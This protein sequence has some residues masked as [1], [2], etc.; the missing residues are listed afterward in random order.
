[1]VSNHVNNARCVFPID[2]IF[3]EYKWQFVNV[4]PL[5]SV[6]L[7]ISNCTL[8]YSSCICKV[9]IISIMPQCRMGFGLL[10]H[11]PWE[12]SLQLC[13]DEAKIEFFKISSGNESLKL[14]LCS[15]KRK[16]YLEIIRFVV[17][18]DSKF[19]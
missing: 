18:K 12:G 14:S 13:Y 7:L 6:I 3:S 17:N 2:V 10:W 16:D 11:Y 19:R 15:I 8:V 4:I 5:F 9:G 1:M